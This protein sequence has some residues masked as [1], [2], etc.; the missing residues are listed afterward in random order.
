MTM[1]FTAESVPDRTEKRKVLLNRLDEAVIGWDVQNWKCAV[2]FWQAYLPADLSGTRSLEIGCGGGGLS[3]WLALKNSQV[4]CSD[5]REPDPRARA[6]HRDW[7]VSDHV[8]YQTINAAS[9]PYE[10]ELDIVIL[11]SVL[12]SVGRHNRFDLVQ[13][14]LAEI[15]K[16]L[17]PGGKLLFAE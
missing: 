13:Q 11:K 16:V 17:K 3:L 2:K 9:I 12:C 7:Q 10:G 5:Y 1:I 14:A 15:H 6:L 4:I 8:S